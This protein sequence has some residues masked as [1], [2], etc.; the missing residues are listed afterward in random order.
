MGREWRCGKCN[1][2]LGVERGGHITL[3]HK[4]AQYVIDGGDYNVIAVC[5]NCST[6][7]ERSRGKRQQEAV[8]PRG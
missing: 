3:R 5:R 4:R 6:V 7:N 2:L 8:T 1:S